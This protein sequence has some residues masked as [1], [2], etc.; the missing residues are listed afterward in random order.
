MQYT[1]QEL[2]ELAA[3]AAGLNAG[4]DDG[5]YDDL[6]WWN[7]LKDNGEAFQLAIKLG[8]SIHYPDNDNEVGV[9]NGYADFY[10][11]HNNSP[12]AATRRAIVRA[13]ADVGRAI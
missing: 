4:T 3:K 13:A 6:K 7:P 10:E 11:K 5:M 1:D 12:Y 2:L 9:G 8:L